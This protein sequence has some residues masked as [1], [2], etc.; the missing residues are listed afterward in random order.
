MGF[1]RGFGIYWAILFIIEAL[2]FV[3][4]ADMENCL[5]GLQNISLPLSLACMSLTAF[6]QDMI[7]RATD[8]GFQIARGRTE[9]HKNLKIA[10]PPTLYQ[11]ITTFM[12]R[13]R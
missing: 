1:E 3:R 5:N 13:C 11:V 10:F 12:T 7:I 2:V 8:D 6:Q 9:S 4:A